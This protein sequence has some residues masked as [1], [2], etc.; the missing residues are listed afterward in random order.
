MVSFIKLAITI[1]SLTSAAIA[2]SYCQCHNTSGG[3]CCALDKHGY[4][5]CQEACSATKCNAGG[6]GNCISS[7]TDVG[8]H[9][10]DGDDL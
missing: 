1:L 10:C 8:R 9:Q 6:A 4:D 5:S 2:C 7:W 3:H